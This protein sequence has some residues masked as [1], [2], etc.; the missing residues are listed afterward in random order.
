MRWR[1]HK[2]RAERSWILS[3]HS[4]HL[5]RPE[6]NYTPLVI[7]IAIGLGIVAALVVARMFGFT[8]YVTN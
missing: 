3:E 2:H 8:I 6:R 5:Q 4:Q 7:G 1:R